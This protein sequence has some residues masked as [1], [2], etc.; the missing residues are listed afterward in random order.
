MKYK[1]S[2]QILNLDNREKINFRSIKDVDNGIKKL[3]DS[4]ISFEIYF[5]LS[6]SESDM[7]KKFPHFSMSN[8]TIFEFWHYNAETDGSSTFNLRRNKFYKRIR[9]SEKRLRKT[10]L[11]YGLK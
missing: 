5:V 10:M 4:K 2:F 3:I 7:K 9:Q 6:Y 11:T 8:K 1:T